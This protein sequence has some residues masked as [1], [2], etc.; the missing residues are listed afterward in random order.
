M[1][2]NTK[3]ILFHINRLINLLILRRKKYGI[4]KMG[5]VELFTT[6]LILKGKG[7]TN[8]SPS[9]VLGMLSF[10]LRFIFCKVAAFF[11]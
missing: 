6:G 11:R 1:M 9:M 8:L 10:I 3:L 4:S 2:L 7:V 5:N